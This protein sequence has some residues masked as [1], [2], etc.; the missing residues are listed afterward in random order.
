MQGK[1]GS[2]GAIVFGDQVFGGESLGLD[3][4]FFTADLEMKDCPDLENFRIVFENNQSN[5]YFEIT[6]I[7]PF[8]EQ[9]PE[10]YWPI[11]KII[12]D[13]ST[14]SQVDEAIVEESPVV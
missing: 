13:D 2:F 14:D 4:R 12:Q 5:V 11:Q 9:K 8:I 3:I 10:N 1:D 7:K 6:A